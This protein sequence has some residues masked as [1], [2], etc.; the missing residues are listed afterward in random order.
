MS[1]SRIEF[2]YPFDIKIISIGEKTNQKAEFLDFQG[3]GLKRYNK[4]LHYLIRPDGYIV[5][6]FKNLSIEMLEKY[7]L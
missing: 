2:E 4:N 6:I 1:F 3:K 5:G 7:M